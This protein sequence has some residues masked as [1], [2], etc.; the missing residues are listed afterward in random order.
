MWWWLALAYLIIAALA[1]IGMVRSQEPIDGRAWL[2]VL[3]LA[4][5]WPLAF[6]VLV[7]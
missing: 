3:L 1:F 6:L 7:V 4:A 2:S 5:F